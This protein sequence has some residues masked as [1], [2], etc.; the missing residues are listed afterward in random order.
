MARRSQIGSSNEL[1]MA[2]D[3][4]YTFEAIDSKCRCRWIAID[5]G[6]ALMGST[7]TA[8]SSTG[9]LKCYKCL[10]NIF[11]IFRKFD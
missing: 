5:A 11:S 1:Q 7:K 3:G 4:G 10:Q 2:T 8:N 9:D 6:H